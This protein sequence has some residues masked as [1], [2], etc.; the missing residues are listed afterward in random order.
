MAR[1]PIIERLKVNGYRLYPGDDGAGLDVAFGSGPWI[2]L[3]V[4]GLGKTTLLLLLRYL[5]VGNVRVRPPGFYGEQRSD[6]FAADQDV[7]ALRVSDGAREATAEIEVSFGA[8]RTVQ[9][10]VMRLRLARSSLRQ[11]QTRLRVR[12]MNKNFNGGLRRPMSVDPTLEHDS[13]E[14]KEN[15]TTL[16]TR[17]KEQSLRSF[18]ANSRKPPQRSNTCC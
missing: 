13:I 6:L 12:N 15:V 7:F 2:V 14:P 3:G 18:K 11:M 5:I 16:N 8:R 17:T 10:R 1:F 9:S 4:N